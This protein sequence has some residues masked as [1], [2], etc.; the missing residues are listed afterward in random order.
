MFFVSIKVTVIMQKIM[1]V[2]NTIRGNKTVYRLT[3]SNP[4]AS[5]ETKIPRAL[6]C[7]S[8]V[9]HRHLN[10]SS[11]SAAGLFKISIFSKSLQDLR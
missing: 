8:G 7:Q 3:D 2:F 11:E 9:D 5:Q 10:V 6:Q 1:L 4:F